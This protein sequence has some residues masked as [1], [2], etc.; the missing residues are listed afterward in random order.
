MTSASFSSVSIDTITVDRSV[1]Q[2]RELRD[3]EILAE[4]IRTVG[5]INPPVVTPELVL[6]A[7]ERR[8]EACRSLGWTSIS[9]QFTDELPPL[10]LHLIE[11]E[12]NVKRLD[13]TWQEHNDA[14][15]TYHKL[16]AQAN[17]EWNQAKTAEALGLSD[18]AVAKHL[19]VAT[20]RTESEDVAGAEKFSSAL[21]M[22][23]RQQERKKEAAQRR[24]TA[25]PAELRKA[26]QPEGSAITPPAPSPPPT[27]HNILNEDFTLWCQTPKPQLFNLIHCDF[28]YG[29]NVG[30]KKG[31]GNAQTRGHYEDT[32]DVYFTLLNAFVANQDNF[33]APSAHLIFWFSMKFYEETKAILEGAGWRVDPFPLIWHKSDNAG[34]IPDANRGPRR[35]YETA[36]FASRGDRKIV[37]P[38]ANSFSGPT[39]KDYHTSEK[40]EAMLRHFFRMVCDEYSLLL[41]PTCGSGMAVKVAKSMGAEFALGLERDPEFFIG[42]RM[43]CGLD[44]AG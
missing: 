5:L 27:T 17:P 37:S 39:T 9:V 8:L 40:S 33:C 30:D 18:G 32:P 38:V 3:V 35:T 29:V 23:Q 15:A 11:L 31:Q 19:L 10:T 41:D 34:I 22:A 44:M 36:L 1:R 14:I 42:A 2:R 16:Q 43:N 25:L 20:A 26:K 4:S 13:L 24:L 12:E 21:N 7:G 28:P 6:V